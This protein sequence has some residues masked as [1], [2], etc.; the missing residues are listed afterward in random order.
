MINCP[1]CGQPPQFS[2]NEPAKLG[3]NT[4]QCVIRGLL[5]TPEKWERRAARS[6]QSPGLVCQPAKTLDVLAGIERRK[7]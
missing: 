3:C 5:M 7:I 6:D 1:F 2:I 4:P